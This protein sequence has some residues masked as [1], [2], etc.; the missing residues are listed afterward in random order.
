MF[1]D[2]WDRVFNFLLH[3]K[4][5]FN[6]RQTCSVWLN[7][8]EFH[9]RKSFLWYDFHKR[10]IE[11]PETQ[12]DGK[13]TYPYAINIEEKFAKLGVLF[14]VVMTDKHYYLQI[15]DYLGNARFFDIAIKFD[16]TKTFHLEE[17]VNSPNI[18]LHCTSYVQRRYR[19][20]IHLT[21]LIF[22]SLSLHI[23]EKRDIRIKTFSKSGDGY[24]FLSD[25]YI[26]YESDFVDQSKF[27][28]SKFKVTLDIYEEH[29]EFYI[30]SEFEKRT[31]EDF[32]LM[33]A[34][35]KSWLFEYKI[36]QKHYIILVKLIAEGKFICSILT[37]FVS[38]K[39]H[40]LTYLKQIN[41][42]LLSE[43]NEHNCWKIVKEIDFIE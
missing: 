3:P 43:T 6:A 12:S 27:K 4:D 18:V 22:D 8:S 1:N 33:L 19:R 2:V 35:N 24:V 32:R 42:L 28:F 21:H 23:R 17:F 25:G 10:I 30:Y 20:S 34:L 5:L 40:E 38:S 36:N 37:K 9:L 13:I 31:P 14:Q 16:E 7:L 39:K 15:T 11:L 41:K 29:F 26:N